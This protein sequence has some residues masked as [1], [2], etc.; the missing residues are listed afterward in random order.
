MQI[1][2]ERPLSDMVWLFNVGR[3]KNRPKTMNFGAEG[4]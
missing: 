4:E 3:P 2:F 1:I